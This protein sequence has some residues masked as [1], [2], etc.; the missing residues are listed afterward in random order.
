MSTLVA[1]LHRRRLTF[2]VAGLALIIAMLSLALGWVLIHPFPKP[3]QSAPQSLVPE[4]IRR[5][6]PFAIYYPDPAKLPAGYHLDTNSFST[7]N[8]AVLYTVKYA[9]NQHIVF[10]VQAK[11]SEADLKTFYA[12]RLPLRTEVSTAVGTAA[13]G[14][15]GNQTIASLPTTG[16]AWLIITAPPDLKPGV[17]EQIIKALRL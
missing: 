17:L 5:S 13:I 3:T 2:L 8:Q 12:N 16:A 15:L 6:V 1:M 10:T 11:P 4:Q 7:G 14:A 9:H